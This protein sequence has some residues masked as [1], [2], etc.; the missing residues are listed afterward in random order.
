MIDENAGKSPV[1]VW[2]TRVTDA[3][4][5]EKDY[6]LSA[7]RIVDI[8]EARR[9]ADVPFNI[10]Y[11]NTETLAPSVYNAKPIPI[12]ERKFKD[13][14]PTAKA[15]AEVA[16]RLLKYFIDEE[17]LS[18]DPFDDL[19]QASVLDALVTNRGVTEF[20]Y[21]AE[22][23]EA[24]EE[25]EEEE[26]V[27]PSYKN[28]CVYGVSQR[29]DKFIHGY[30]R[31][32]KRVP[33]A[34]FEIDMPRDEFEKNFP[35]VRGK[36]DYSALA[37]EEDEREALTGETRQELTGVKM[38]KVYK[39]WDKS[40][41]KVLFFS[42]MYKDA[43]LR[44][45]DDP[46]ELKGFY[47][48]PRPMN[49]FRK[50]TSLLPVPL[51]EFYRNQAEEL[52]ALTSR[53]KHIIRALK[54]RGFYDST[55]DG[56]EKVLE[57]EENVLI[58]LE[59]RQAMPESMGMDKMIW[60]MPVEK[61]VEVARSLYEQ[62]GQC[63]QIIYEITGISDILRGATQASETATAQQ[64]KNQWGT[65]RL[66][67]FQKEVQRY[68]RDCL[69]IMLE[70]AV[71]KIDPKTVKAMTGLPFLFQEEKQRLEMGLQMKMAQAQQMGQPF[72]VPPEVQEMLATPTWDE[73]MALLRNDVLRDYK[74]DIE[75]NSTIDAEAAQDKQDIAELMNAIAQFLNGI[76]PL[77]EQGVLPYE[78]AKSM[79]LMIS[80]RFTFGPQI[81]DALNKMKAPEAKGDPKAEAEQAKAKVEAERAQMEFKMDE[82]KAQREEQAA[83]AEHTRKMQLMEMEE[84]IERERLANE[85]AK[86]QIEK[87]RLANQAAF[88]ERQH[89]M[90]M[91]QMEAQAKAKAAPSAASE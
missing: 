68:V 9:P 89:A 13:E 18:F 15:S 61:L 79:L 82:A 17:S 41:R 67:K 81:E 31:S 90:K 22:K 25:G 42:P 14:D 26:T 62:R 6:R 85:Q 84:Q 8:Y 30:A 75:T 73:I 38:V 3:L 74:I 80:R 29:W 46:L 2:C 63:K 53:L 83:Q 37:S 19:M 7:R 1:E 43:M 36:V 91:E 59:N 87:A 5:R 28:E 48:F 4:K 34:G 24:E 86:L 44:E 57:A 64:I 66:K 45:L 16:T 55:V 33:W 12:V 40:S 70:I 76:A 21:H 69:R 39:I 78:V 65:L 72:E 20:L 11:S 10:L 51:Y 32:W 60:L 52:N 71:T 56:I 50:I 77:V 49:F 27:E 88:Q 54:I 47:P 35:E 23:E 58:P